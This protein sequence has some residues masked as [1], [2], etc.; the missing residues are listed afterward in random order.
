MTQEENTKR[1]KD[2]HVKYIKEHITNKDSGKPYVFIS[3][4]SDDWYKVLHDIV[5][6]LLTQYGLNIYYDGSFDVHN[7][8]WI[9][10]FPD[11]MSD[12]NCKGVLAFI[13]EKYTC[14]Y[15]TLLELMYSQTLVAAVGGK[16]DGIGLPVIPVNLEAFKVPGDS[17]GKIDTGLGVNTYE[18]GTQNLN[19]EAEKELFDETFGELID[20]KRKRLSLSRYYYKGASLNRRQCYEVMG[21]LFKTIGISEN[22]LF[23]DEKL[24]DLVNTIKNDVGEEVFDL[25]RRA[26]EKKKVNKP[27]PPKPPKPESPIKLEDFILCFDNLKGY[28]AYK[29]VS[30]KD[31]LDDPN[32]KNKGFTGN[33]F[34]TVALKVNNHDEFSV[35]KVESIGA[36]AQNLMINF[37][38]KFNGEEYILKVNQLNASDANPVF[39]RQEDRNKYK[40]S[41][42]NIYKDW[43]LCTNYSQLAWISVL[44]KRISELSKIDDGP[45]PPF[46]PQSG[47]YYHCTSRGSNAIIKEVKEG[48][49][50][51]KGSRRAYGQA[52][53]YQISGYAKEF[54]KHMKGNIFG[55]DTEPLAKSL[56]A[57]MVSLQSTNGKSETSHKVSKE[58]AEEILRQ[59]LNTITTNTTSTQNTFST[60]GITGPRSL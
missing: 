52:D 3:Y 51:L 8:S 48:Y 56:A 16:K 59:N 40:L 28:G 27:E 47:T 6:K 25:E 26:N 22:V 23:S 60:N 33:S 35:K 1:S 4:K 46:P 36:L 20:E 10:Q 2:E 45:L 42:K 31:F 43:A 53:S 30:I 13:D 39:V 32:L 17:E 29:E 58:K 38:E 41:Y 5:Y 49:I 55:Q 14:S 15:A 37:I 18:D 9:T 44:A 50:I 11:N 21:E 57:K 7:D 19:A 34:E 12:P 24:E 54:E